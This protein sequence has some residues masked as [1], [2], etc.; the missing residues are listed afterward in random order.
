[1]ANYPSGVTFIT[2][3]GRRIP[4]GLVYDREQQKGYRAKLRE[5]KEKLKR[6]I[7][8]SNTKIDQKDIKKGSS[9]MKFCDENGVIKPEREKIHREIIEEY[10]KGKTPVPEGKEK[11]YYMTG[12]GSG[13]GKS[14]FVKNLKNRYFKKDFK[15]SENSEQFLGN[16]VKI[17]AD[18]IKNKLWK[19]SQE[20][21]GG[22]RND[23]KRKFD[24]SYLHEESSYLS[25]RINDI[26][27][28]LGYNTM[29]DS[30]GDGSPENLKKKIMKAKNNGYKV[31]AVYG[32]C[33]FYKGLENNTNRYWKKFYENDP[34]ARYVKEKDVVKLHSQVTNTLIADAPLFD[35]VTLYDMNNYNNI[36]KI[37]SAESGGTLVVVRGREKEYNQFVEKGELSKKEQN[38]IANEYRRKVISDGRRPKIG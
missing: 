32:T 6:A 2:K 3:N 38:R 15:Y 37:A 4:I 34:T 21:R 13:T 10:F 9:A 29:L 22:K 27:F 5:R 12:G 14:N 16:M 17:D 8:S 36:K 26:S 25:K 31:I 24:A 30:T 1:M 18:D 33:D 23:L 20:Y 35:K 7:E 28:E 11:L 19:K